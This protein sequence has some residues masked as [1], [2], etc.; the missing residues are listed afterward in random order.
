MASILTS[1]DLV[2]DLCR[3]SSAVQSPVRSPLGSHYGEHLDVPDRAR[4]LLRDRG[5]T[6]GLGLPERE[7][8]G[9]K[10]KLC[11]T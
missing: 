7:L 10:K 1:C 9:F 5:S 4:Q 8:C 6:A 11:L 2:F 3:A